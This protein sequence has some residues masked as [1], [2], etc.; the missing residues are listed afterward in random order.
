MHDL[1][2]RDQRKSNCQ[3]S[4]R[5]WLL[6]AMLVG[7]FEEIEKVS[8]V[9]EEGCENIKILS[10]LNNCVFNCLSLWVPLINFDCLRKGKERVYHSCL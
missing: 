4:L 8:S 6:R 3:R 1:H 10:P 9:Q 5:A 2:E 7:E